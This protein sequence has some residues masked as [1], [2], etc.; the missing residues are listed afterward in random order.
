MG[1]S[2]KHNI[3]QLGARIGSCTGS[4]D[5]DQI[6]CKELRNTQIRARSAVPAESIASMN[7][8]QTP[9]C[10]AG[11]ARARGASGVGQR[12]RHAEMQDKPPSRQVASRES[13][14]GRFFFF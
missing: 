7:H 11:R 6:A 5:L 8:A 4:G 10:R 13:E 14:Y 2:R 9:G 1:E 3:L 12:Q